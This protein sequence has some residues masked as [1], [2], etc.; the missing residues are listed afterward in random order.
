MFAGLSR[1]SGG[2]GLLRRWRSIKLA[3]LLLFMLP[4]KADRLVPGL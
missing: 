2:F 1:L 4:R 3:T